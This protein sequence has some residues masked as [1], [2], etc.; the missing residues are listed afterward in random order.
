MW[1]LLLAWFAT[2]LSL[3]TE[4]FGFSSCR[5]RLHPR[6]H[7]GLHTLQ[8]S[9]ILGVNKYSH[10]TGC[11]IID[12]QTGQVLFSQAKERFSHQKHDGGD[13]GQVVQNA[14]QSLGRHLDEIELVVVNNHHFRVFPF[15]RRLPFAIANHYLPKSY[16]SLYNLIPHA[17]HIELSH[18]LAHVWSAIATAPFDEGLVLVMDG[19]GESYKAM[20]EDMLG[21]EEEEGSGSHGNGRKDDYY[22]DLKLLKEIGTNGFIGQP[23]S[24]SPGSTYREAESAYLFHRSSGQLKPVFKR[25]TRERSPSELYNHGF[26]NMESIG[27]IYSRISSHIFGDW[28]ACGKVMGLASWANRPIFQTKSWRFNNRQHG[29]NELSLGKQFIHRIPLIQGN[30]VDGSLKIHWNTIESLQYPNELNDKTFAYHAALAYSIQKDLEEVC[31]NTVNSLHSH[32]GQPENLILTGGVALNSVCN[33]MIQRSG[34]FN[35]V[36]VPPA[37]GDDGIALGCA[38]YGLYRYRQGQFDHKEVLS[39]PSDQMKR[40]TES[41]SMTNTVNELEEDNNKE[42]EK[43]SSKPISFPTIQLSPYQGIPITNELIEEALLDYEDV[44]EEIETFPSEQA[45]IEDVVQTIMNGEVI[46]W[47]QGR[48]ELG[49]RALGHRSLLADPRKIEMRRKINE[50]IKQREWF[51]P[52]APSVLLEHS[53]EWFE[54]MDGGEDRQ[55]PYMSFT[56]SIKTEKRS[57]VPAILHV[58]DTARLQTVSSEDDSLYYS[59]IQAFYHLTGIPMILN[60][61]LNRRGQPIIEKPNEVI[62]SMLATRGA[63]RIIYLGNVK[64]RLKTFPLDDHVDNNDEEENDEPS[65][66]MKELIVRAQPIYLVE[67][68]TSLAPGVSPGRIVKVRIQDGQEEE[69]RGGDEE[70][71]EEVSWREIPSDLHLDILQLLQAPPNN[72]AEDGNMM[73]AGD[74]SLADLW[75]SLQQLRSVQHVGSDEDDEDHDHDHEHLEASDLGETDLSWADVRGALHWLYYEGLISFVSE[76][77]DPSALFE[78]AKVVDLRPFT[79]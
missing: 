24:L 69:G 16:Q 64:L 11:S 56:A 8:A 33:G 1:W 47:F 67:M 78:G 50:D 32:T 76:E 61:S 13:V 46:A 19:M 18:H 28:N 40:L 75:H 74:L 25:W 10:D 15:E 26:E 17:K 54:G 3:L 53:S 38:M 71:Q 48:S 66:E 2:S 6:P 62:R 22:H 49:Q 58:D 5:L 60:T 34:L 43:S 23:H 72:N 51:R 39:F 52:F 20:I 41:D 57:Q 70:Q 42:E 37:P 59:L 68:T 14:L 63:V 27:A 31:M 73:T 30:P 45:L 65:D 55:S 4:A 12:S 36:Y 7:V 44:I 77:I 9:L 21:V 79:Q 29:D 35:K